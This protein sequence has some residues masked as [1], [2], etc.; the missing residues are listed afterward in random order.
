MKHPNLPGPDDWRRFVS[1]SINVAGWLS[2]LFGVLIGGLQT[3]IQV[4]F[5]Y[6]HARGV[7]LDTVY[8][9]FFLWCFWGAVSIGYIVSAMLARH[10]IR[11]GI[12]AASIFAIGHISAIVLIFT[13]L[14]WL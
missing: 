5:Y 3:H 13:E 4:T 14:G 11:A 9:I 2:L 7:T 1:P 10:D 12:I 8:A 6:A